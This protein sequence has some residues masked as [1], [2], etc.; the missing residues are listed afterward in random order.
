M[1]FKYNGS[2]LFSSRGAGDLPADKEGNP[3]HDV[4]VDIIK[5]HVSLNREEY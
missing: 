5:H 3:R 4:G 1:G 2:F